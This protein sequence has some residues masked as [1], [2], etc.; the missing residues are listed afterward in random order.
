MPT[1]WPFAPSFRTAPYVVN[2]EY[3]TDIITSRSGKEQARA[4][5]QTPRKRLEYTT[6]V[7]GDCRR[8]FNALMTYAQRTQL[9]VPDRVRF[10]TVEGGLPSSNTSIVVDPIP[11]WIQEG[12]TLML[13]RGSRHSIRTVASIIDDVVIFNESEVEAW[14]EGTTLHPTLVGYLNTN[15]SAPL[16]SQIRGITEVTVSFE[17]DPGSEDIPEEIDAATTTLGGREAFLVRPDRWTPI[18]LGRVQ[19][20]YGDVDF[21]FGR[22]S[23]FFPI[24]FSTRMWDATYTGCD[25]DHSDALRQFFDRMKGKHGEFYM[26]TWEKDLVP[27][28]PLTSAGTAMQV[29]GSGLEIAYDD[30]TVW[31]ALAVRKTDGTWIL[32]TVNNVTDIGTDAATINISGNWGQNVPLNQ[33]ERVCWMPVWR[34]ASDILATSWVREDVAEVRMSMQMIETLTVE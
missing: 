18:T 2:R 12:V 24:E 15:I 14:P 17:V 7:T 10:I 3:R 6:R 1:V 32:R 13:L 22:V 16:V 21:G 27:T 11:Y 8:E 31:K 5:R 29:S 25:F 28:A 34:F 4:L 9:I 26:P 19:N 23:R 30:S 33:I 20:G